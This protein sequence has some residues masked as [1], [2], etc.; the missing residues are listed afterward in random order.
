[1]IGYDGQLWLLY[2]EMAN[3]R[4]GGHTCWKTFWFIDDYVFHF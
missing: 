1:M 3:I 2:F 4:L